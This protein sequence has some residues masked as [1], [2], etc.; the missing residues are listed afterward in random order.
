MVVAVGC[1]DAP[2]HDSATPNGASTLMY[3]ASALDLGGS[4]YAPNAGLRVD[5]PAP[6]EHGEELPCELTAY[7]PEV[8][9]SATVPGDGLP[10]EN[11]RDA[12]ASAAAWEARTREVLALAAERCA[13]S[14]DGSHVDEDGWPIDPIELTVRLTEQPFDFLRFRAARETQDETGFEAVKAERVAQL[15]PTQGALEEGVRGLGGHVIGRLRLVNAVRVMVPVCHAAAVASLPDVVGVDTGGEGDQTPLSADGQERRWAVGLPSGDYADVNGGQGSWRSPTARVRFGVIEADNSLNTS[16]FS[17]RDGTGTSTRI[18]DTDRCTFWFPSFRCINSATTTTSTHGT[19][20]THLL[21]GDLTDGQDAAITSSTER[22]KRSGIAREGEAHYYSAASKFAAATA[23]DEATLEDGID[24]INLSLAPSGAAHCTLA[25]HETMKEEIEAATTA[26]VLVVAAAGNFGL[27]E[28]CDDD[29]PSPYDS[30]CTVSSYAF[31]PDSLAV[32][33][34]NTVASLSSLDSVS[35]HVCSSNGTKSVTLAG[36]RSSAAFPIDLVTNFS[37]DLVAT[38]GTSGYGGALGTSM[39]APVL[40]GLAGLVAD[41]AHDRGG[42]GALGGDPYV[43]RTFLS[44]MG[45]GRGVFLGVPIEMPRQFDASFGLGNVRFADVD[46]LGS[47]AGFDLKRTTLANGSVMEWWVGSSSPRSTTVDGWKFVA[48][49]DRNSYDGAPDL[50]IELIDFCP[51]GGGTTVIQTAERHA[52]KYRMRMSEP[53]MPTHFWGR[54][55]KVRVTVEHASA[56]FLFYAADGFYNQSRLF[57]DA[58][59]F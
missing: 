5:C 23:I 47:G 16:H 38:N 40:A 37:H 49:I 20:V 46:A 22:Q 14:D 30:S 34:T 17:F 54:C 7:T 25:S 27:E 29:M 51:S 39:S 8:L 9:S 43:I 6:G 57:H 35:R 21:L 11:T 56:P 48:L 52:L 13:A 59:V 3:R 58:T 41:W 53:M 55:L 45:D 24:I 50:K 19:A 18:V 2:S 36:G 26:G 12:V 44:W 31:Y 33:G 4:P 32:G 28:G 15:A 42:L 1:A 10:S